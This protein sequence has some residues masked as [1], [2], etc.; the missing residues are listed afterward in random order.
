MYLVHRIAGP[1]PGPE[2]TIR[3]Y[4]I[5]D[6]LGSGHT[7]AVY[8]AYQPVIGRDVAVKVI[9]P[10]FANHP[11][12][13]R[14]F[15]VEAQ[16]VARLEHPH[17]VPLYDYW[18]D[19]SG[20][21][22]VMRWLKGGSLQAA[23]DLGPWKAAQAVRLVNQIA[24]ALALAHHQGV[25]HCDIKPANILLDEE[26]N[27]YLSDFGIAILTGQLAQFS[28]VISPS[29]RISSPGSLGYTSPEATRGQEITPLTDIYS[30]GVV[31]YELL[32]GMHPFPGIEGRALVQKHLSEPLPSVSAL[33]PDLP[34]M[35]DTVIQKATAKE[36][37]Q[38]YQNVDQLAQAFRAVVSPGMI[39]VTE[40]PAVTYEMRNPYKGLRSF[41][42][43][44]SGTFSGAI[45]W[46]NVCWNGCPREMR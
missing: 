24:G 5:R 6:H 2:G 20:A 16:L 30:L 34:E 44:D 11:D 10:Q 18:R 21:Y 45:N 32:T 36:P 7:G 39:V 1:S 8:K 17:I 12:F 40:K 28:Q 29:A 9:L 3:G 14:R 41:E 25:V 22:L 35:V 4:K 15:E 13:I 43:A 23:L 19:P 26:G 38:R 42:E 33:R 46:S 37:G 27:A 31:L